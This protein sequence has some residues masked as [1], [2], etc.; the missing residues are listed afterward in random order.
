LR[1]K[2]LLEDAVVENSAALNSSFRDFQR[3][4]GWHGTRFTQPMATTTVIIGSGLAG[5]LL[6]DRLTQRVAGVQR[7]VLIGEE[8]QGGYDRRL[9]PDALVGTPVPSSDARWYSTRG[10]EAV[11]GDAVATVD[12]ARRVVRTANGRN[13]TYDRLVFAT[14]ALPWL[15]DLPGRDLPGVL[16]LRT[17]DDAAVARSVLRG[18][19]RVTIIGGGPI[20]V[21]AAHR[22]ACAGHTV[23]LVE[24][25]SSWCLRHLDRPT[26]DAIDSC[27]AA[28]GVT[29]FPG[30]QA[31]GITRS[32]STLSVRLSGGLDSPSD[33]VLVVA[34]VRPRDEI[35]AACGLRRSFD[36]GIRVDERMVT[37]DPR[38][39]ALGECARFGGHLMGG[40]EAIHRAV[41]V[42]IA[43]LLEEEGR[44]EDPGA[45]VTLD[46]GGIGCWSFGE[47]HG[48]EIDQ[49]LRWQQGEERRTV[50]LRGTHLV[51]A[52][53]F[54]HW[55]EV[56]TVAAAVSRK[57]RLW[58]WQIERFRRQGSLWVDSR[59]ERPT[60]DAFRPLPTPR[61]ALA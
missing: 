28:A 26:A 3:L 45:D 51:G 47:V 34:G 24:V 39:L 52:C 31:L 35:A 14:G 59:D 33:L 30:R 1:S 25:A 38:V 21:T 60:T 8:N 54:G 12:R 41:P 32:E 11:L 10:I 43:S 53:G 49:A 46:F 36:G 23:E 6:A 50:V 57:L 55:H 29:R 48:S 20:G 56:A 58:P 37:D 44:F 4:R 61:P 5:H 7:V 42:V 2:T 16:T 9:L 17:P 40:A 27:L 15:P 18:K 22:L 19:R 13:L